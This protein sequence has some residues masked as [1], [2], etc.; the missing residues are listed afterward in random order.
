MAS[1]ACA[2]ISQV[3]RMEAH[4]RDQDTSALH[5]ALKQSHDEQLASNLLQAMHTM[6]SKQCLNPADITQLYQVNCSSHFAFFKNVFVMFSRSFCRR[7]ISL[8]VVVYLQPFSNREANRVKY[9]LF[10]NTCRRIHRQL[11]LFVSRSLLT[12]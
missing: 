9:F 11:S 10:S 6:M 4:E 12:C 3:L 7:L 5:I 2:H 1:A 8:A